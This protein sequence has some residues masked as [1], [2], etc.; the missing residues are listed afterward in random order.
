MGKLE[1]A[2]SRALE[3][4]QQRDNFLVSAHI[5]ADGDAY[6]AALAVARY[7]HV[8]G[9]RYQVVF[10]DAEADDRYRFLWGYPQ[11]IF[12]AENHQKRYDAAILVDVSSR[13]RLG[14]VADLLPGEEACLKIDHHPSEES[15]CRQELQMTEAS[16]TCRLIY[17]MVTRGNVPL[18][19]YQAETLFT[20]L[21][22]DTGRFSFSNTSQ[23]DFEIAAHLLSFGVDPA[24]VARRVF[25][26]SDI[27]VLKAVGYGLANLESFLEGRVC[28]MYL[29]LEVMQSASP[30]SIEDLANQS[31]GSGGFEVGI[32]IRQNEPGKLK[33]S[34]RSRGMVDVNQVARV[35]GGGGHTSAAGCRSEDTLPELKR[36]LIEEI[37]KQL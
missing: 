27:A 28:L 1:M 24:K 16:S 5:N 36:K 32:F 29:P 37:S 19:F 8:A 18:D 4:I 10:H 22:F 21:M 13:K 2:C 14:A 26:S 15:F 12:G 30:P 17:E 23:R 33:V 11:I 35:F 20:G 31:L 6:G 3:F 7:L 25:F 9:K 34:L